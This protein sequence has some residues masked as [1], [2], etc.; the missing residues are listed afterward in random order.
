M[1]SRLLIPPKKSSFFLFGPRGV[2]KTTWVKNNFPKAIY[3]DL[4]N[5]KFFNRLFTD[6]SWIEEMIPEKFMDWIVIDEIQRVP[7]LL[8][9]IHRLIE[10]KHYKFILTGSNARKL[11]RG[12]VNLLAGRALTYFMHPLTAVELGKNFNLID[13]FHYG[14]LPS[15]FGIEDKDQYLA[16]YV[17]TYLQQEVIQ[18]GISRNLSAFARFL[19]TASFSQGLVLNMS[20][21]A[22]E[23][24]VGRRMTENYFC[25]LEDLL[26]GIKLPVFSKK[27]KRKLVSHNKFYFFD[28]GIYRTLRPIS[29]FD[30]PE[31]I[32]GIALESLF[33]QNIRAVNDYLNYKYS[34]FYFRTVAGVEV[35][36][37]LYGP[38]GLIAFEIKSKK[39]I[40]SRDLAGLKSFL[41]DYPTA[42]AYLLYGGITRRY[43]G[44]VEIIPIKEALLN[45]PEL[46]K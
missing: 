22:R 33:L 42:R 45:L 32:G 16:S 5:A 11:R 40:F 46:L 41:G 29:Q 7:E 34:L 39:D 19:E 20:E 10:N 12:G 44:K 25:A 36:F 30:Q 26:I 18:E 2:G 9:E 24:A 43:L 3:V 23:A 14:S 38:R 37:V 17:Q 28:V 35:D 1:Y 6:P 13:C 31:M 27:A 4:L 8:N 15:V 21:V